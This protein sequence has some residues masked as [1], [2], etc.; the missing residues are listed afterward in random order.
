[1]TEHG[2][3]RVFCYLPGT[4]RSSALQIAQQLERDRKIDPQYLLMR[5]VVES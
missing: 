5:S 2:Q 3:G 4:D 1:M